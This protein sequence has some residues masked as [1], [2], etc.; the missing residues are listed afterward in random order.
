MARLRRAVALVGGIFK[1][2]EGTV[3]AKFHAPE[4][5]VSRLCQ[6]GPRP[7]A[8]PLRVEHE[9]EVRV[10]FDAARLAEIG[11]ARLPLFLRLHVIGA[12][13]RRGDDPR[14]RVRPP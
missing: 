4:R 10:L 2:E 14:G 3:L 13:L 8:L 11:K 12:R 7:F 5:P 9:S 1:P 6:N